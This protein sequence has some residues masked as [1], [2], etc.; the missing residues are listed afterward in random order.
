[1][2]KVLRWA[3]SGLRQGDEVGEVGIVLLGPLG[4]RLFG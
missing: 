2:G 3:R 1:M 4:L